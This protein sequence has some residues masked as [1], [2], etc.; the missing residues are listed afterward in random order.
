[1][2]R[3]PH[4]H[5]DH[6]S[7]PLQSS[8]KQPHNH[9]Q[10]VTQSTFRCGV[11]RSKS[12]NIRT[13]IV[14]RRRGCEQWN[15]AKESL[16][17]LMLVRCS[18]RLKAHEKAPHKRSRS[19]ST[20][21]MRSLLSKSRA[22]LSSRAVFQL[23]CWAWIRQAPALAIQPFLIPPNFL[24]QPFHSGSADSRVAHRPA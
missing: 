20:L 3:D 5:H 23:S 15:R 24:E 22:A 19:Q 21:S 16:V 4:Y 1:M 12:S 2:H 14:E 9:S 17:H 7:R 6:R 10:P 8:T 11:R 13:K 18:F